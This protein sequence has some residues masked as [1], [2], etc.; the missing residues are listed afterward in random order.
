MTRVLWAIGW[1]CFI[2]DSAIV[3]SI[4]CAQNGIY[5]Q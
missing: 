3:A 5:P 2:A 4:L 1:F